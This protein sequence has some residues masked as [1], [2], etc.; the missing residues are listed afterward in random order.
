M[1]DVLV[2][3]VAM[4]GIGL[5]TWPIAF[6][7]LSRLPDRG[8]SFS[9]ALGLILLGFLLFIGAT[10][11]VIP[12]SRLGVLLILLS[13]A[14]AAGVIVVR[15]R[16][17]LGAFLRR[18]WKYVVLTEVLFFAAF[19]VAA[20]L[21]SYVAHLS[22]TEKPTELAFLN[23]V[24]KSEHF[25]VYDPWLSPESLSYY[26]FGFIMVG[27]LIKLTSVAPEIGFNL[28]L[29]LIA[30]LTTITTFGIVYNLVAAVSSARRAITLG[31]AGVVVVV[32]LGNL[33]G[34]L[35]LLAAHGVGPSALYSWAAIDGLN[36]R[37]VPLSTHWYPD[38][39]WFFWRSTRMPTAWDIREYPFFSFLLGDLHPHVMVMP[40]TMLSLAMIFNLLRRVEVI[41][42]V[43]AYRNP[44]ALV[45]TAIVIGGLSFLNAWSFPPVVA[46]LVL[47]VFT[48]NYWQRQR[49]LR[50]ALVDTTT[51]AVP[52]LAVAFALYSPFYWSARG[53]LWPLAPI[54]VVARPDY[55]PLLHMVTHPKHLFLSW[56]P[57]LW[58]IIGLGL[59][60][61]SW[62]SLKSAGGRAWL[63]L[64]PG[65]LP[66]ALW[67]ILA[68][69]DLGLAGFGEELNARGSTLLTLALLIGLITLVTL[70]FVRTLQRQEEGA[71]SLIVA[72]GAAGIGLLLIY[73]TE[74]FYV[75][76]HL[77][78]SRENTVFKL[79]HHAWLF[80]GVGG[81]FGLH[82]V[83]RDLRRESKLLQ[84]FRWAWVG[85]AS[86]LLATALIFP[87]T[88]TFN[89]TN[90]FTGA[91][92]LDGLAF[93][94]QFNPDEYD[95]VQWLN[96][97]IDGTPVL[98]EAVGE[99]FQEA[100]RV[101]ARTGLPVILQWPLHEKGYRG[102]DSDA[103]LKERRA[104]VDM[105][106][107]S[108]QMEEAIAVFRKYNV[109]YVFV[110]KSER[111]QYGEGVDKF[112][113]ALQTIY[114]KGSVTIYRVPD[115]LVADR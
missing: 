62:T 33:E 5:I 87:V 77:A 6:V 79:H 101:S 96:D 102:A 55:L 108:P 4:G 93:V 113:G 100:G 106:Y 64:L 44:F 89:R 43:W 57:L 76:D 50:P 83:L 92:T 42:Y 40:F 30:G 61:L 18:R 109:S 68:I 7:S 45:L 58:L 72:L 54:E 39:F 24:L 66:L 3:W 88:A 85:L 80:I 111:E 48:R 52:F 104:D 73:G 105:A 17:E 31:L 37:D 22:G 10:A 103:M 107:R 51:F 38:S 97:N 71:E 32:L 15:Q 91:R 86:V 35:E 2:W 81:A 34:L 11:R 60:G 36:L 23:A 115:A 1:N 112:A 69:A 74:L 67:A 13:M 20:F 28:A 75:L 98:L 63:A 12:N 8:Y 9:K 29:A 19:V 90:G 70:A 47:A 84:S 82:C 95:A 110:G 21:R 27:G 99:P 49:Q 16:D 78:G 114:Q 25:P 56:G 41:N 59:T 53:G 26:Y 14:V 46:L 94:R 65:V